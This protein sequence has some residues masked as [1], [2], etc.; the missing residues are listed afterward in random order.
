MHAIPSH[1][2]TQGRAKY[3]KI[4]LTPVRGF[5]SYTMCMIFLIIIAFLSP[6]SHATQW[7]LVR[8]HH[9]LVYA[10][11]NL[12]LSVGSVEYGDKVEISEKVKGSGHSFGILVSGRLAYIDAESLYLPSSPADP[13]R[14]FRQHP[15]FLQDFH[16]E[17]LV[18][19]SHRLFISF[20]SQDWGNKWEA[21]RIAQGQGSN[22]TGQVV[23]VW[24]EHL[25][26]DPF[27]VGMGG[28]LSSQSTQELSEQEWSGHF[29]TWYRLPID[30]GGEFRLTAQL[31]FTPL[32][33][34][35]IPDQSHSGTNW[36]FALGPEW[37]GAITESLYLELMLSHRFTWYHDLVKS[38]WAGHEYI[39]GTHSQWQLGVGVGTKF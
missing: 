25:I 21:M 12:T 1:K 33:T 32:A 18:E 20:A 10:D 31:G 4:F 35:K 38:D 11:Q 22:T 24:W 19:H 23:N 15:E 14:N 34:I 2:D 37:E 9:A 7:A 16:N 30:L 5:F 8:A 3:L 29:R 26:I 36:F 28:S 17:Y 13:M 39:E 6:A 27:G